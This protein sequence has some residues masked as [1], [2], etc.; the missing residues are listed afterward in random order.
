MPAISE[1]QRRLAGIALSIKRGKTPRSYSEEAA[2]MADSMT[3]AQLE[4]FAR[5]TRKKKEPTILSA[6]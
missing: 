6:D 3:E 4:D 2:H 1:M 5:G